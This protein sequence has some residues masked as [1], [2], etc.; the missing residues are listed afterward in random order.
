MKGG[1]FLCNYS[2]LKVKKCPFPFM[3]CGEENANKVWNIAEE[4]PKE[5][6]K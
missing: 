4:R 2:K 6:K 5:V 1:I 3:K